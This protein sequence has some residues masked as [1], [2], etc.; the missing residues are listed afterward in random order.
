MRLWYQLSETRVTFWQ[1]PIL[2]C[3]V[4]VVSLLAVISLFLGLWSVLILW[5]GIGALAI[6]L[7]YRDQKA[8]T[9][10]H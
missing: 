6:R 3:V 5:L 2:W 10:K 7:I 1:H 8:P 4:V 9:F